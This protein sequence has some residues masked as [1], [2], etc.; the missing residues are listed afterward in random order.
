MDMEEPIDQGRVLGNFSLQKIVKNLI[1][2][3]RI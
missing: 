3:K 2:N 1:L